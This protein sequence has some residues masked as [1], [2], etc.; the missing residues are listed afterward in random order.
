M[1]AGIGKRRDG[2]IPRFSPGPGSRQY[3]GTTAHPWVKV[4]Q[5][6]SKGEDTYFR[7]FQRFLNIPIEL[8]WDGI[9][10]ISAK[11]LT[12][13]QLSISWSV[14]RW[15]SKISIVVRWTSK[16]KRPHQLLITTL[17]LE[18]RIFYNRIRKTRAKNLEDLTTN[19]R[20]LKDGR[21][22]KFLK[23]L[24]YDF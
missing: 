4:H 2:T 1:K 23:N 3:P 19:R 12:Q 22:R 18:F 8:V 20:V 11:I 17:I 24:L 14:A 7:Y 9:K 21:F 10:K 15:S 16:R 13:V 6:H 5:R